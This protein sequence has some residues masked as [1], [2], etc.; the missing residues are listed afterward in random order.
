LFV[1]VTVLLMPMT[2]V[3]V[4][5][6]NAYPAMLTAVVLGFAR[7][8]IANSPP[9]A[10]IKKTISSA[11]AKD[12]RPLILVPRGSNDVHEFNLSSGVAR[13]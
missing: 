10:A 13:G 3:T 2:T 4:C 1:H 8:G 6:W 9:T 12:V 5:G 7:V 11:V